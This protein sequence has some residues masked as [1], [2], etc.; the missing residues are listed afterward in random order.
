[1]LRPLGRSQPDAAKKYCPDIRVD[2]NTAADE[3]LLSM[4]RKL[5]GSLTR[6]RQVPIA[7]GTR[8]ERGASLYAL[9]NK[10]GRPCRE[11]A[12]AHAAAQLVGVRWRRYR[13]TKARKQRTTAAASAANA[14]RPK[15]GTFTARGTVITSA[16]KCAVVQLE[17]FQT[18]LNVCHCSCGENLRFNVRGSRQIGVAAFW[19]VQ[20]TGGCAPVPLQTS[21][22][23]FGDDFESNYVLQHGSEVCAVKFDHMNDLLRYAD[24]GILSSRDNVSTKEECEQPL[25]HMAHTS[26]AYAWEKEMRMDGILEGDRCLLLDDGWNHGR[27]GSECT[28]P[29]LSARTGR[30]V[31]L[32]HSRRSDPG[33]KSSQQL[34]R[35]NCRKTVSHPL[36]QLKIFNQVSVDGATSTI[37]TLRSAGFRCQGD[38]WHFVRNRGKHFRAHVMAFA[39]REALTVREQ[40]ARSLSKVERPKQQLSGR[41]SMLTVPSDETMPTAEQMRLWLGADAPS[42]NSDL[43][44]AY[45]ALR[46]IE[47][48]RTATQAL[49]VPEA[50]PMPSGVATSCVF[51]LPERMADLPLQAYAQQLSAL[52]KLFSRQAVMT[53]VERK[54]WAAYDHYTIAQ[55][56]ADAARA[57][58]TARNKDLKQMRLHAC[59]WELALRSVY[60]STFAYT[61][62]LRGKTNPATGQIWTDKE[63]T[64]EAQRLYPEAALSLAAGYTD[65]EA[66]RTIGHAAAKQK[67][68]DY[69]WTPPAAGYIKVGQSSLMWHSGQGS[70][71][72]CRRHGDCIAV[73]HGDMPHLPGSPS[74]SLNLFL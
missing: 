40:E 46:L 63:R 42:D 72:S 61:A 53:P 65:D 62:G 6:Q 17:Q 31:H 59:A 33:V 55:I 68:S 27:N 12:I 26:M 14:A 69:S 60:N 10:V 16:K 9:G 21:K 30:L 2:G 41:V 48:V 5:G 52:F 57:A 71:Q 54:S 70:Y 44:A 23:L 32:E 13:A 39:P 38:P 34:E 35:D 45:A 49:P 36:L 51:T 24:F 66:L 25:A 73:V 8:N 11:D 58:R 64:E 67:A 1:M 43:C 28:Q 4:F 74:G 18:W 47:H 19:E 56:Y 50:E 29:T 15:L 22:S 37:S 3:L 7:T 20:C